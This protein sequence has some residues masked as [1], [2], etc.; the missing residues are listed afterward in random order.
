ANRYLTQEL[1]MFCPVKRHQ[2]AH[3]CATAS[4]EKPRRRWMI[5][6]HNIQAGLAHEGKIGIHLLRPSEIVA[7][8]VRLEGAV[9]DTFD[10]KLFV[11]FQKEF[12]RRANSL[13]CR[14]YHVEHHSVIPSEVEESLTLGET[15]QK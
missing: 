5:N 15:R 3:L 2:Y 6:S 10:E 9:C 14:R 4:L 13:I 8:G 1:D 11:T 12:R 7:L